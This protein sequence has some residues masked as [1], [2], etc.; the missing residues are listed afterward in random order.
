MRKLIG[1]FVYYL[2]K[3]YGPRRAWT[4]AKVTL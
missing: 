2:R 1:D 4:L 3:G